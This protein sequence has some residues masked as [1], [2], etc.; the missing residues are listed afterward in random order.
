[1]SYEI[2]QEAYAELE[3][4]HGVGN[5]IVLTVADEDFAFRRPSRVDVELTLEARDRKEGAMLEQCAIRCL[6]APAAPSANVAEAKEVGPEIVAER[7]RLA[8][9]FARSQFYRDWVGT[10]FVTHCG[11]LWQADCETAAGGL[12]EIKCRPSEKSTCDESATLTARRL[13]AQEYATYRRKNILGESDAS[14]F[15]F[16]ACITSA[17][18]TEVATR[19]PFLVEDICTA[20]VS[21]GSEGGAVRAKKF[22]PSETAPG[23]STAPPAGGGTSP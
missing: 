16:N 1:M 10:E 22:K 2:T 12:Y 3:R 14:R 15:V 18:K 20:L 13:T 6:L 17:N 5:V 23:T 9:M 11:W 19:Y 7:E 4:S 21:L 8:G